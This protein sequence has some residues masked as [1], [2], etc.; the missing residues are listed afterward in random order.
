VSRLVQLADGPTEFDRVFGLRARYVA[1]F[2]DTYDAVIPMVDPVLFELARLR[3]AQLLECR[4]DQSMRLVAA[5]DAGLTEDKV[6][7][8]SSYATSPL[9]D[10][11]E[12]AWLGYAEMYA[13]SA[14]DISDAQVADL[15]DFLTPEELV[16][17]TRALWA[18]D[19]LQRCCVVFGVG[20]TDVVPTSL[21]H[22]VVASAA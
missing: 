12:R 11:R 10:A 21:P 18:T 8:L 6:A 5:R 1:P 4:F 14:N 20:A 19:T 13:I 7:A 2:L 15:L 22:F 17:L 3:L 9:F 16:L